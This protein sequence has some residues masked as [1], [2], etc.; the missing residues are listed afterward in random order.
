LQS[1]AREEFAPEGNAMMRRCTRCDRQFTPE[2]LAR[3]ESKEME[4]DRKAAGLEGVRFL[5]YRCPCGMA[6]YFVDL[7][8]REGESADDLRQRRE[9]ME[10]VAHR[11]SADLEQ[12]EAVVTPAERPRA[13]PRPPE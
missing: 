10:V 2:N 13:R 9:A 5:A 3:E 4:A 11:L 12:V 7:L 1:R 6:D 8:S